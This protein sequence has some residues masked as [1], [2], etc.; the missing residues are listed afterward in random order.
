MGYNTTSWRNVIS[1]AACGK[2]DLATM[3]SHK[4]PLTE[5]QKGFDLLKDQTAIKILINPDK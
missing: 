4:L 2:L 3:V 5:I 1:L